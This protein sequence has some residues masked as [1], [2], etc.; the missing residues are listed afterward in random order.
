[1]MINFMDQ[2]AELIDNQIA[3]KILFLVVFLR[4]FPED[5]SIGISRLSKG[6]HRQ[7][8]RATSNPLVD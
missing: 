4:V 6:H 5:I 1:M 8:G 2:L 7:C 3:G